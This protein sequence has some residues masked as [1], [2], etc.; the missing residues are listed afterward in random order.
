M[1]RNEHG[2]YRPVISALS[3]RRQDAAPG[4]LSLMSRVKQSTSD[5][6]SLNV[7]SILATHGSGKKKETYLAETWISV[8]EMRSQLHIATSAWWFAEA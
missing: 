5:G 6:S 3:G 2:S 7:K 8:S 4:K 1:V